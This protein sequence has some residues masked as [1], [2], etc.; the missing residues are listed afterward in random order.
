MT[1][2]DR[3]YLDLAKFV[4][5]WSKDPSTQVGAVIYRPNNSLASIGF[6]GLPMGVSDTFP[7]LNDRELKLMLICHAE[8]NAIDF[9]QEELEGYTICTWPFPPCASCAGRIIQNGI[10]RVVAPDNIPERWETN[11]GWSLHMFE[12]AGVEVELI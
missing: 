3:R 12:E 1:P 7:R 2:W 5:G 6:N 11:F 8:A 9:S 4:A 10:K